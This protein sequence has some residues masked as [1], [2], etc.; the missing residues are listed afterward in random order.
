MAVTAYKQANAAFQQPYFQNSFIARQLV[1][2]V[3][4]G[5]SANRTLH[6]NSEKT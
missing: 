2:A 4:K 6:A 5:K 3:L 1:A